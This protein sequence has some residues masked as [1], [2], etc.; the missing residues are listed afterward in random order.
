MKPRVLITTAAG[1]TGSVA[2]IDLVRRGHPVRG[3][4]RRD[5][6]PT[7]LAHVSLAA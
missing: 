6:R 3:M 2:A 4:V 5:D 7:I 1:R